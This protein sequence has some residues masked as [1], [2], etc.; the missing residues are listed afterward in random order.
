[1]SPS[2][3]SVA[4]AW[5]VPNRMANNASNIATSSEMSETKKSIEGGAPL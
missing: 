2:W 1:M 3:C 4:S 5:R